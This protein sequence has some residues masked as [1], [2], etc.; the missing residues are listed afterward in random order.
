[1]AGSMHFPVERGRTLS[2]L[3][4]QILCN[5]QAVPC[6]DKEVALMDGLVQLDIWWKPF[7]TETQK[8]QVRFD[9]ARNN[10]VFPTILDNSVQP[11]RMDSQNS[12]MPNKTSLSTSTWPLFF[13]SVLGPSLTS[14]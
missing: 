2:H 10:S 9:A 4:D 6:G 14:F 8:I 7:R 12:V 13:I 3:L 11:M 5:C 1:M